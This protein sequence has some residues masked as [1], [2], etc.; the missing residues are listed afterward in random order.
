MTPQEALQTYFHYDTFRPQQAEI[1]DSVLQGHDTLALLPTGGGKSLCYQIPAVISEGVCVVVSPLIALMKDQV[2]QLER[3]G[4][5]ARCLTSSMNRYEVELVLNNCVWGNTKLLYVAPERLKTHLFLEHFKQ[6][7]VS[8]IAVDEAHCI[9]QWGYNFR[10][11]YLE[12]ANIRP[13]FPQVPLLALTA[14]AT[15]DVMVDIQRRL[16]FRPG[17]QMFRQSFARPNISYLVIHEEDKQGR[18]LNILRHVQGA[19]IVYVGNRRQT[20]MLSNF[21]NA[22]GLSSNY[23]H[24]GLPQRER[25]QRQQAWMQSP[26]GIMVA[27]NAFGMGIDRGD[28]HCVVHLTLPSSIEAYYQEAGR[29]GRDGHEAYAVI[30]YSAHDLQLLRDHFQQEYPSA[31]EVKNIYRAVCNYY[32]IPEGSGEGQHFDFELLRF[33]NNYNLKPTVVYSAFRILE[34]EGVLCLSDLIPPHSRLY[35]P[36]AKEDVYRFQVENRRYGDI[37]TCI[38]RLYGGLTAEFVDIDEGAIAKRMGIRQHTVVTAL[39]YMQR[40][41]L[42]SYDPRPTQPQ[43]LFLAPRVNANDLRI[44]TEEYVLMRQNGEQRMEAMYRYVTTNSCR[45]RQILQ[46]FGEP[47][48]PLCHRCDVCRKQQRPPVPQRDAAMAE[49]IRQQLSVKAM[50]VDDLVTAIDDKDGDNIVRTLRQLVDEGYVAQDS[51]QLLHWCK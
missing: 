44:N 39:E 21:L 20:Q 3:R 41:D 35:I 50:T 11:S 18:L 47:N 23:Y 15:P 24:A 30:L 31:A 19:S 45:S 9:S 22:R 16:Q 5:A 40:Q 4:I 33:C 1:I 2:A 46:Y 14:S 43:I 29:V 51:L 13:Y 37:L 10:P 27:T 6:M 32:Q 12:I 26:H 25:D 49:R 34:R 28:V 42:V 36:A 17:H 38:L 48:P 8:L 7:K